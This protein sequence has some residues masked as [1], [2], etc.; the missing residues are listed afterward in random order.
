MTVLCFT[1]RY[2]RRRGINLGEVRLIVY[3]QELQG[4]QYILNRSGPKGS[5]SLIKQW[6]QSTTFYP[7]QTVVKD[8]YTYAPEYRESVKT[9]EELYE[10]G[11]LCF[12]FVPTLYGEQA[13]VR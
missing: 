7:L 5:V 13:E 10:V 6:S 12:L 3:A 2:N 1:T 9:L 4:M 11:D 8:I